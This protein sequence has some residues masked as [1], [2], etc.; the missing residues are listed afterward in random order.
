MFESHTPDRSSEFAPLPYAPPDEGIIVTVVR[1]KSVI[2]LSCAQTLIASG[3]QQTME[4]QTLKR[5]SIMSLSA[6]LL[7]ATG[8]GVINT[9]DI[10]TSNQIHKTLE[11]AFEKPIS[12]FK[13]DGIEI[14]QKYGGT[15]PHGDDPHGNDPHD[16]TH[17]SELP[18]NKERNYGKAPKDVYGGTVPN[19][20]QPY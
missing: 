8:Y 1:L 7:L 10:K 5:I 20:Q 2:L 6:V 19:S 4:K 3:L 15:D 12:I 16:E 13:H 14:A 9:F 11:A 17:D 18:A